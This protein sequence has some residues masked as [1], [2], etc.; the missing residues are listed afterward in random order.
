MF[1]PIFDH[2]TCAHARARTCAH[3][4]THNFRYSQHLQVSKV[5]IVSVAASQMQKLL[6]CQPC[7]AKEAKLGLHSETAAHATLTGQH[8]FGMAT[9]GGWGIP[10]Y[11]QG[12]PSLALHFHL[13]NNNRHYYNRSCSLLLIY[14]H[15]EYFTC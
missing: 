1:F 14:H 2:V 12:F 15:A 8:Y 10:V 3:T 7:S 11:G 9:F 4:H 13:C 5:E 6:P